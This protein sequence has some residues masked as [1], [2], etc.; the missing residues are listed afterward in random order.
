M[1]NKYIPVTGTKY[2]TYAASSRLLYAD[3][4]VQT[5]LYANAAFVLKSQANRYYT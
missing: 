4:N 2:Q 1:R 3:G 5:P